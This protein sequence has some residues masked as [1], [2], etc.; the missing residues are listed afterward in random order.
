[1]GIF[2]FLR[3]KPKETKLVPKS[4]FEVGFDSERAWCRYP[5]KEEQSLRRAELVGVA[6]R[7]TDE[8]PLSPDVFF[9]LGTNDGTLIF[10]QGATGEA[11]MLRRLQDLPGFHNEALIEAMG[12]TDNRTFICWEKRPEPQHEPDA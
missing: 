5:G 12:C 1:V 9:V 6:V 2:S 8:G 3:R 10:P 4:R 7:T 11:G